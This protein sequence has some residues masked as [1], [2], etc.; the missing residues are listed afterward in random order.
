MQRDT[1]TLEGSREAGRRVGGAVVWGGGDPGRELCWCVLVCA[2]RSREEDCHAK[3]H[4]RVDTHT[5][6]HAGPGVHV[7]PA[8]VTLPPPLPHPTGD[9]SPRTVRHTGCCGP[10]PR[11]FLSEPGLHHHHLQHRRLEQS[12]GFGAAAPLV[13]PHSLFLSFTHK[14]KQRHKHKRSN[15]AQ[16]APAAAPL[17]CSFSIALS[18]AKPLTVVMVCVRGCC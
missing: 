9:V 10:L 16:I 12:S 17:G 6:T 13:L 14:T 11:P 8:H 18:Y 1:W 3:P 5:H 2:L 15:R 4:A 7:V